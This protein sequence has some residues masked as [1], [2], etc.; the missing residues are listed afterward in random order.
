M[1]KGKRSLSISLSLLASR[2]LLA[3]CASKDY[4]Y[5][6]ANWEDGVVVDAGG[7][8][9]TY[10]E[11]YKRFDGTKDASKAQYDV[12]SNILAQLVTERSGAILSRVDSKRDEYEKTWKNNSKTN[13]TSVK[14][15]REKTLKERKVDTVEELR[16]KLI[17]QEQVSENSTD[18]YQEADGTI[19]S[20]ERYEISEDYTKKYVSD[21]AP[22]HVSHLLVKVDASGDG[23]GLWDGQIS[24]DDAKQI[25]SVV[26]ALASSESFGSVAFRSSDDEGSQKT[27]GELYTVASDEKSSSAMVAREKTT[28]Y[29][30]EFKLGL[31]AYDAYRNP[32]T[33]DNDAVKASLRVPGK[34]VEY[35]DKYNEYKY[36]NKTSV[37]DKIQSTLIGQGKAFGIPLSVAFTMDYVADLESDPETGKSVQYATATQYPRNIY[38][39]N[40]F[41]YEGASFIYNDSATYDAKFLKEVNARGKE[42]FSDINDFISR[43]EAKGL[44]SKLAEYNYVK[45]KL[46][47][48]DAN[49]FATIDGISNNLEN[50]Y[51][52]PTAA[53][54][55]TDLN[56]V[57]DGASVKILVASKESQTPVFVTRAASSSYQGIHFIV[58]NRNPFVNY[59]DGVKN[60]QYW[61]TNIPKQDADAKSPEST[62]YSQNPSFINFIKADVNSNSSY[63]SRSTTVKAAIYNEDAN[64]DYTLFKHNL[65]VF[66]SKYNGKSFE[67]ILGK[68]VADNIAAYI[69]K[70][71]DKTASDNEESLDTSWETYVKKLNVQEEAAQSRILP[72]AC[73]SAFESGSFNGVTEDLC[74]V[75]K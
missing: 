66:K 50:Y 5:P 68:E 20:K 30:N 45:T 1:N 48:I 51:C 29:V 62:D 58:V 46:A 4:T 31:Y 67:D 65:E 63:A 61:R 41:N 47:A 13:K 9:Y 54:Q 52:D 8:T 21:K 6:K 43:A 42:S 73:V 56:P 32:K 44:K 18:F 55:K 28:S 15:E 39:N 23:T 17:S 71:I 34:S 70:T 53:A 35:K 22:Y 26:S 14:E 2:S 57:E 36:E 3:G 60:Y 64:K 27:Y 40:Y 16:Q 38:F 33:K 7:K 10:D 69:Q 37:S 75:K 25:G 49:K 24:S 74:H 19:N 59:E 72:T 12:A 11:I